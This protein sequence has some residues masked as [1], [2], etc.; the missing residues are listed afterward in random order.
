MNAIVVNDK[1]T[2]DC[3]T[4]DETQQVCLLVGSAECAIVYMQ[5]LT[6]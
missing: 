6:T 4:V 2:P 3:N 1:H 5:V